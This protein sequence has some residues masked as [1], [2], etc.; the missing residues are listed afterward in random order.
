[1]W[2]FPAEAG[3]LLTHT[4]ACID[5]ILDRPLDPPNRQGVE[6]HGQQLPGA[7]KLNGLGIKTLLQTLPVAL[8]IGFELLALIAHAHPSGL[9]GS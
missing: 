5:Q 7:L 3:S 2:L 4:L 8:N 1:M 9:G 6:P